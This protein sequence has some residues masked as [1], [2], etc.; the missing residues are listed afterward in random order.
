MNFNF[1]RFSAYFTMFSVEISDV[2][3]S[4]LQDFSR[5]LFNTDINKSNNYND[6]IDIIN[7]YK[8]IIFLQLVIAD[9]KRKNF[10]FNPT[11][12]DDQ[13]GNDQFGFEEKIRNIDKMRNLSLEQKTFVR[14]IFPSDNYYPDTHPYIQ[15]IISNLNDEFN[16]TLKAAIGEYAITFFNEPFTQEQYT[17][18]I[19]ELLPAAKRINYYTFFDSISNLFSK[20][21]SCKLNDD[22]LQ[23][24]IS[25]LKSTRDYNI[26]DTYSKY[27]Q[28]NNFEDIHPA[29]YRVMFDTIK[30]FYSLTT[31]TLDYF[32]HLSN[33]SNA[34]PNEDFSILFNTLLT[35][36]K[37]V[38]ELWKT[39]SF[40][41]SQYKYILMSKDIDKYIWDKIEEIDFDS[42]PTRERILN[43]AKEIFKKEPYRSKLNAMILMYDLRSD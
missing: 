29:V 12:F 28:S 33:I 37:T 7:E 17:I 39:L 41:A 34:I 4:V 26:F 42:S 36:I 35:R 31:R 21:Y 22:N 20:D 25:F 5:D 23:L 1:R 38:D 32:A 11:S 10:K 27:L 30:N 18:I 3:R 40:L 24:L 16:S 15:E 43:S 9:Y 14:L 2:R 6:Y 19:A 8:D 13:F